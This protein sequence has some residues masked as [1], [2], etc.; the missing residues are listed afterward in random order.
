MAARGSSAW[1]VAAWGPGCKP[2]LAA[3]AIYAGGPRFQ[4]DRRAR[5]AFTQLG[6]VFLRHH[7]VIHSAGCYNCRKITG[8]TSLSSH[9]WGTSLDVNEG[10]NPY[11]TDRLVT[12]MTPAM[13][14][15]VED[16]CTAGGV[17]VFRWGGDWDGRPETPNS[18]YDAM[19]FEIIA[20]PEE[21]AAGFLAAPGTRADPV[22]WPV[23]RR[24]ATGP[25][26][27]ALQELLGMARTTG[28]GT[29]GP[30]TE[31][32]VLLYQQ[33]HGLAVDGIVGN[34]TWTA[35]LTHQPALAAGA[36]SPRKVV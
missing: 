20:T 33:L 24:G 22:T 5:D 27:L 21:L 14:V 8:G 13:I 6:A 9:S 28:Q 19:H 7:Y 16:I 17:H 2:D 26:V 1:R 30:R 25:A 12:D 23:I 31:T 29:F 11:R 35:L 10:T 4:C 34:G 36:P 15:D 18:N 32:A 3:M